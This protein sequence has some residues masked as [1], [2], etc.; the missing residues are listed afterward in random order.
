MDQVSRDNYVI[1]YISIFK[2]G[3]SAPPEVVVLQ[4]TGT[5]ELD[6]HANTLREGK[7]IHRY[8]HILKAV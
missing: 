2:A 8:P 3:S 5:T 1:Q 7:K 4:L 6:Y